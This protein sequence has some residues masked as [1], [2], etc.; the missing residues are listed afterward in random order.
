MGNSL[1]NH[2]PTLSPPEM[3]KKGFRARIIAARD[4]GAARRSQ[5]N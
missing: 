2:Y 5:R 3:K 1:W 4:P